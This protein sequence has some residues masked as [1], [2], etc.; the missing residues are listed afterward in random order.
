MGLGSEDSEGVD[1]CEAGEASAGA[2]LA[3]TREGSA[4]TSEVSED[5]P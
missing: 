3:H 1:P 4:E 2:D 5:R